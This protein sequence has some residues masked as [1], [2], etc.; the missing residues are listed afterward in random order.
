MNVVV[1]VKNNFSL[2]FNTLL[3]CFVNYKQRLSRI[4]VTMTKVQ[5]IIQFIYITI[6]VNTLF[7]R[8]SWNHMLRVILLSSYVKFCAVVAMIWVDE[9][10]I[11]FL[12]FLSLPAQL[13]AYRGMHV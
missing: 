1:K 8:V 5:A 2:T 4:L 10:Y 13:Q 9:F 3:C 7:Y 12:L 6:L 11:H